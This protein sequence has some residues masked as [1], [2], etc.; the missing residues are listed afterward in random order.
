[1][2]H[3]VYPAV[4]KINEKFGSYIDKIGLEVEGGWICQDGYRGGNI[5]SHNHSIIFDR[6]VQFRRRPRN[7]E[8]AELQNSFVAGE[9]NSPA[10]TDFSEINQFLNLYW[11]DQTNA[12]CGFHIHA[13]FKSEDYYNLLMDDEFYLLFKKELPIIE[14][15]LKLGAITK[16]RI[17]GKNRFCKDEWNPSRQ[18][19][20]EEKY[21]PYRYS[22]I[23]FCWNLHRTVE[24]RVFSA[25]IPMEKSFHLVR[26]WVNIINKFLATKVSVV[27]PPIKKKKNPFDLDYF[28]DPSEHSIE[29]PETISI[30][31]PRPRARRVVRRRPATVEVPEEVVNVVMPPVTPEPVVAN[32]ANS[33]GE[34]FPVASTSHA[35]DLIRRYINGLNE[36][37]NNL[38][39]TV[40]EDE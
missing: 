14:H 1:M 3:P 11:P 12:S 26:W 18:K 5:A 32:A 40:N 23:N 38:Y 13:S 27:E 25:H 16:R 15:K 6:S 17:A 9:I 8:E 4:Y 39:S 21:H 22:M 36:W 33:Y 24:V 34:T 37:D 19:R 20:A 29:V 2:P 28:I 10:Y 35:S 7:T 30:A 31:N